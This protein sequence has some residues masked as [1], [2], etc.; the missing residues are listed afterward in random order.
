VWAGRWRFGGAP[1]RAVPDVLPREQLLALAGAAAQ[2]EVALVESKPDGTMKQVTLVVFVR[3]PA[4]L[5]HDVVADVGGY[6]KFVPN[7]V[8]TTFAQDASGQWINDWKLELPIS[9][10]SGHDAYTIDPDPMGPIAFH[11]LESL[12]TYRWDF[13]PVEGGT[14]LVQTG[15][16]DVLHANRF[17]RAFVHRQPSLEHGLGLAAQFMEVSAMRKEAERRSGGGTVMPAQSGTA[18]LVALTQRGMVVL[19]RSRDGKLSE[20]SVLDRVYAPL[21]KLHD[22]IAD[23]G[24]Y[25]D[26]MAGVDRSTVTARAA[27]G[28]T[29]ELEMALPVL[30]WSTTYQLKVGAAAIDG[31][32]IDG[33]LRGARFRWDLHATEGSTMVTYRASQPLARSSMLVRKLFAVDA[34]LE[35]GLNV[36]FAILQVRSMRGR[37]EG[38]ATK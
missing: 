11:S 8:Q 30:T 3:A 37:A 36:A 5:V 6:K 22:V 14:L 13:L 17:V 29:Y 26:F 38:W 33:D 34:S 10:F 19:M 35:Y 7:L 31:A 28:L 32:G 2:G 20:V 4:K 16:A 24:A 23:P 18:A 15:Y 9:S 12:A 27:D 21:A 1:P 25:K